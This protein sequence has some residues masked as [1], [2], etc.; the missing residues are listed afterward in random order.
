MNKK[1][2][3]L[4]VGTCI[5]LLC[6]DKKEKPIFPKEIKL[7]KVTCYSRH[8]PEYVEKWGEM[9]WEN[10]YNCSLSNGTFGT[11]RTVAGKNMGNPKYP[12]TPE[13]LREFINL[14]SCCVNMIPL[15]IRK[16]FLDSKQNVKDLNLLLETFGE[17]AKMHEFC[18]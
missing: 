13:G 18:R 12:Y 14:N 11:F 17:H 15:N 16:D 4:F 6:C 2:M 5:T 8:S 10:F 3:V 1:I 9:I 7:G